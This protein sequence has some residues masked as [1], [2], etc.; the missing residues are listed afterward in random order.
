VEKRALAGAGGARDGDELAG[1]DRK[2][3]PSNGRHAGGPAVPG[4]KRLL[5]VLGSQDRHA[6]RTS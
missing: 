4:P 3:D 1:I 6:G 5:E 2:V